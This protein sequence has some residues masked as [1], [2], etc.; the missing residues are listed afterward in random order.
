MRIIVAGSRDAKE[1]DVREAL[2][3]C[4]WIGFVTAIVSGTAKG[5]DRFGE[6]WAS[7]HGVPVNPFPADWKTYGKRAGPVR[8]EIMARN[9]EGLIAIWNGESRGTASMIQLAERYG[10]RVEIFRTD[11]GRFDEIAPKGRLADWWEYVEERAG[12]LEFSAG[13]P[14]QKAER[15]SAQESLS[16]FML[17]EQVGDSTG[18]DQGRSEE[19]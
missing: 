18:S 9:A 19:S 8:N 13:L 1:R 14:R 5:A 16:R 11:V 3:T 7:D 10:L 17:P 4:P 6:L 15:L 12:V 2:D